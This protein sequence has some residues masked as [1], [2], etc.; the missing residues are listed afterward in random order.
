MA[1]NRPS[2]V[3]TVSP[4]HMSFGEY[5]FDPGS[6]ELWR[7]GEECRLT[8]RAASLLAVLAVRATRLVTKQEFREVRPPF[9]DRAPL[10]APDGSVWVERSVP[11]GAPPAWDRF[12]ARGTH[13]GGIILPTG[14]RLLAAGSRGLYAAAA[15]SDGLERLERYDLP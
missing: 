11:A 15:D 9:T 13:L 5:R 1:K 4:R 14:R 3:E 12:D 6:G 2:S 7:G 10:I 8:P